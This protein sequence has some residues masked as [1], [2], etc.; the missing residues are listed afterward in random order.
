MSTRTTLP[1]TQWAVIVWVIVL[2]NCGAFRFSLRAARVHTHIHT[3]M[4]HENAVYKN[5]WPQKS[6]TASNRRRCCL[7]SLIIIKTV[8]FTNVK[9]Q[10]MSLKVIFRVFSKTTRF[11]WLFLNGAGF[12]YSQRSFCRWN[13]L[14]SSSLCA[15]VA[16]HWTHSGSGWIFSDFSTFSWRVTTM[17]VNRPMEISQ[18]SQLSLSSFR[19]R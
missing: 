5:S 12:I 8:L 17:W 3:S 4:Q 18:L 9:W 7:C 15:T 13:S 11:A 14:L 10:R 1:L 6:T 16:C 2:Q 19:G